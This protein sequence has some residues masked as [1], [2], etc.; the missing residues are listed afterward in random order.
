MEIDAWCKSDWSPLLDVSDGLLWSHILGDN[1]KHG[2]T[3]CRPLHARMTVNKNWLT[4]LVFTHEFEHDLVRP[5]LEISDF[6]GLE[7]IIHWH[8]VL[9]LNGGNKGD[10]LRAVEHC[11]NAL[12]T[13]PLRTSGC[14]YVP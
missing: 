4:S 12:F 9:P 1:E 5:E 14:S 2:H 3:R 6:F 13:E 11:P 10:V 7:I 8:S